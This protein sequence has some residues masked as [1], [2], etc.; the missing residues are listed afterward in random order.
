MLQEQQIVLQI[1]DQGIGIPAADQKKLFESFHRASNV[2]NI[3]GTGLGLAIVKRA[4]EAHQGSI[5][6]ASEVGMGTTVSVLLPR[7]KTGQHSD[8]QAMFVDREFAD[9]A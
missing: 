9:E 5:T 2:G 1:R 6:I 7:L 3:S 4:V 8:S